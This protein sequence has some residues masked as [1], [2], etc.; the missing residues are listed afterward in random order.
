MNFFLRIGR[1]SS[2]LSNGQDKRQSLIPAPRIGRRDEKLSGNGG[3]TTTIDCSNNPELCMYIL[4]VY[5]D[6]TKK[7][8]FFR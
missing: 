5:V 6:L 8:F 2:S 1:S 7:L 3:R 4:I